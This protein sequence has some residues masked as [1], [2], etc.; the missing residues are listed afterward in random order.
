MLEPTSVTF[1]ASNF[2][3]VYAARYTYAYIRAACDFVSALAA[4]ASK[5]KRGRFEPN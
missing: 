1:R 3:G 4:E 5:G 2:E